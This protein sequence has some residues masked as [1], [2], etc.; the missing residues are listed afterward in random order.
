M[1]QLASVIPGGGRT[2]VLAVLT[3]LFISTLAAVPA[4]PHSAGVVG[5]TRTGC[6]C[7][8]VTESLGVTPSLDGLPASW[9]PGEE[10]ALTISYDGGPSRGPGARAGFDLKASSGELVPEEGLTSVR[11]DPGSGEA[12]HTLEGSNGSEW[13]LLWRAPEEGEG[14]VTFVLVVNAVNGDGVQGPGDQWGRAEAVVPEGEAGGL[15]AASD[16]WLVVGV[17]AVLAIAALAWYATRGPRVE[18]G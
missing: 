16:L 4:M 11:V 6:T 12:T 2:W 10:Y 13:R 9:E 1:S 14:D 5:K 3:M 18:R 8:N 17:A 7:H 15:G